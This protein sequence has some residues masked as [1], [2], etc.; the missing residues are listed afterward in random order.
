M[1]AMELGD[2]DRFVLVSA[3]GDF[4][5]LLDYFRTRGKKVTVASIESHLS[6]KLKRSTDE[7]IDL[8]EW[9]MNTIDS[10]GRQSRLNVKRANRNAIDPLE[11]ALERMKSNFSEKS[12]RKND[13]ND[14]TSA[15]STS[16]SMLNGKEK[17]VARGILST[18]KECM[19]N[20]DPWSLTDEDMD[21]LTK[22]AKGLKRKDPDL[23]LSTEIRNNFIMKSGSL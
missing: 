21:V 18:L 8:H 23:K 12:K 11:K 9:A 6:F 5:P 3:D 15:I 19:E 22:V 13:F 17:K 14:F 1:E 4:H 16:I 2:Y 20:F 7:I 10:N